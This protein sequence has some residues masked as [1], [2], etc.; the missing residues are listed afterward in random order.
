MADPSISNFGSDPPDTI[1]WRPLAHPVHDWDMDTLELIVDEGRAAS[2]GRFFRLGLDLLALLD[3]LTYLPVAWRVRDL[4]IGSAVVQIAPPAAALGEERFLRLAVDSLSAVGQGREVARDWTPD[5]VKAA[6]RFVQ[7]AQ[8]AE[9]DDGWVPPRLRL[10]H[11]KMRKPAHDIRLTSELS[12]QLAHLQPFE[13]TMPGAVRG[14]LV[15]FNVSRGNRASLK[16]PTG[17]VVRIGFDSSLR[18]HLKEALMQEVE[19]HGAVRQDGDGQIF[20]VRAH[21][22]DI[23]TRPDVR[24]TDLFGI[25]PDYTEGLSTEE[26]LEANRGDA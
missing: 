4:R 11:D 16:L 3:E 25:D 12:T 21:D 26:W 14:T 10:I 24:W 7:D 23:L 18:G 17:R 1:S 19:V 15:G 6:H 9:D 22:V 8:P 13:R 5:A 20:H 2:A